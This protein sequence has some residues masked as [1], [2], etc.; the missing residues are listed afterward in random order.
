V[1]EEEEEEE[2]RRNDRRSRD[3]DDGEEEEEE[4]EGVL[5]NNRGVPLRRGRREE[6]G[7]RAEDEDE[8][9][10][11]VNS[12]GE[13]EGKR[14]GEEGLDSTVTSPVKTELSRTTRSTRI[15][16]GVGEK[17]EGVL[18]ETKSSSREDSKRRTRSTAA[19]SLTEDLKDDEIDVAGVKVG[20]YSL[21][22]GGSRAQREPSTSSS[23]PSKKVN[24][25]RRRSFR[26]KSEVKRFNPVPTTKR[27]R[28]SS[29]DLF[30][31]YLRSSKRSKHHFEYDDETNDLNMFPSSD[32]WNSDSKY[33]DYPT[34]INMPRGESGG[35][36]SS[37]S[38]SLHGGGGSRRGKDS[39]GDVD[40]M[41]IDP[42]I[43]WNSI[44]GLD[45]HVK[46][47]KEMV[48][49]PL[50]YPEIFQRFNITPPRGVLF[51]GPP[52]CGKTLVARA[53]ANT[54]VQV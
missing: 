29:K 32:S 52:G 4:G 17:E 44:G 41:T 12:D 40:P 36:D 47:L 49:F 48:M 54:C 53:L 51:Y 45:H 31:I 43:N 9:D 16:S 23:T 14:E 37:S 21:R 35:G 39:K 28:T 8:P 3:D 1:D 27:R 19:G 18:E 38:S 20:T 5:I 24:D 25:G 26:K 11:V 6:K 33:S 10:I 42:S 46:L 13:D 2:L 34:P 50:L 7:H 22:G 30:D 15:V